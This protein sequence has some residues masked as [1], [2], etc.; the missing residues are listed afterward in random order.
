MSQI[1]GWA[2]TVPPL[3]P[4]A[5]WQPSPPR[6]SVPAAATADLPRFQADVSGQGDDADRD[7]PR[8]PVDT[9]VKPP[10]DSAE[11]QAVVRKLL[12]IIPPGKEMPVAELNWKLRM[13]DNS[14]WV[15]LN[16]HWR[17]PSVF[18][19]KLPRVF[20]LTDGGSL[21]CRAIEPE[22]GWDAYEARVARERAERVAAGELPVK[23]SVGQKKNAR[24][25]RQRD[26]ER[27]EKFAELR[28]KMG[29]APLAADGDGGSSVGGWDGTGANAQTFDV[30]S[31][32]Q[33][34]TLTARASV[35]LGSD[36]PTAGG[37]T[38]DRPQ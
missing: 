30:S 14:K 33:A 18:L 4:Q 13:Q 36:A 37:G 22:E 28:E 32:A 5:A 35:G 34:A 6:P 38:T 8:A 23:L 9:G 25:K 16:T 12:S 2:R 17:K 10:L 11:V 21:V 1:G 15:F 7:P 31:E 24:K 26:R 19:E 29:L 20:R 27:Q 3:P